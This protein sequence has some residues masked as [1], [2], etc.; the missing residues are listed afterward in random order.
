M[1]CNY[2]RSE[3]C[4]LIEVLLRLVII[5]PGQALLVAACVYATPLCVF[6]SA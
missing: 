3:V 6:V 2:T 5:L 4:M 1:L